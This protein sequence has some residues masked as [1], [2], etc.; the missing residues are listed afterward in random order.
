VYGRV[1]VV[2]EFK[3]ANKNFRGAKGV[4]IATKFTQKNKKCTDFSTVCAISTYMIGFRGCRIQICY[5]NFSGSKERYYGNQI[6][7]NKPKLHKFHFCIK[8]GEIFRVNSRVLG[9]SEFTYIIGNFKGPKRVIMTTEF[10]Q[11]STKLH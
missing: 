5:L 1:S 10:K 11:T 6:D 4:A 7:K 2:G 8:H 9:V 3:Y